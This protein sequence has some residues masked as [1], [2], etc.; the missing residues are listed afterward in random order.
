VQRHRCLTPYL[1][2]SPVTEIQTVIVV[3]QCSI[4]LPPSE[5]LP[6]NAYTV[7]PFR[8]SENHYIQPG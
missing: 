4:R 3:V 8:F 5:T 6:H 2:Y 7:I 1:M